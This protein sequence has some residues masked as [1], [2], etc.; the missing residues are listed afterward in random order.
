MKKVKRST[1]KSTAKAKAKSRKTK[2]Q[3]KK[4]AVTKN[5][6]KK[7][8][9]A[10]K[11]FTDDDTPVASI[12][13]QVIIQVPVGTVVSFAGASVPTGW[14]LCDGS[15]ISSGNYPALYAL[16]NNGGVLPNLTGQFVLGAGNGYGF[17]T[18]GGEYAHTLSGDEIPSHTHGFGV[19]GGGGDSNVR[20][21]TDDGYSIDFDSA[22]FKNYTTFFGGSDAHNN[23][24][25]YFVLNYIIKF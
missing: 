21:G 1:K 3:P 9:L 24:P 23:M 7:K 10:A 19:G 25:P 6:P 4:N 22:A 20:S 17:Y 5:K 11:R 13:T 15:T 14:L 8:K 16:L 12:S 2:P 18:S